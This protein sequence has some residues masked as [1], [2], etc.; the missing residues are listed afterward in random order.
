MVSR[1]GTLI[2]LVRR[3]WFWSQP[4]LHHVILDLRTA[5]NK[6]SIKVHLYFPITWELEAEKKGTNVC[7]IVR[8]QLGYIKALSIKKNF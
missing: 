6:L 4:E 3:F 2:P 7:Y 8:C 1:L 5:V